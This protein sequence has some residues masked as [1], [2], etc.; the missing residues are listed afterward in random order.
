MEDMIL[1]KNKKGFLHWRLN[2]LGLKKNK[3]KW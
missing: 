2:E 3:K 1:K